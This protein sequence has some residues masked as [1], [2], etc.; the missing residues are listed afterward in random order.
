MAT[1]A[2][3]HAGGA[4]QAARAARRCA[5]TRMA[6]TT[7]PSAVTHRKRR[8]WVEGTL[9]VDHSVALAQQLHTHAH[10]RIEGRGI[11]ISV[12]PAIN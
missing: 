2:Y 8:V 6:F 3:A 10:A 7:A 5:P 12:V 1:H 9:P 4:M 11:S